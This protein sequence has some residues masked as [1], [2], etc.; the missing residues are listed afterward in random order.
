MA[1]TEVFSSSA[2]RLACSSRSSSIARVMFLVAMVAGSAPHILCYTY[3][4]QTSGA[5]IISHRHCLFRL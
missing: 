5:T 1:F 3:Y 4:V 2:T